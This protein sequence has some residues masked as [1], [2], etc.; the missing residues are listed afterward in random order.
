LLLAN[1]VQRASFAM[2]DLL[3]LAGGIAVLGL[4]VLYAMALRRI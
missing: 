1:R 4:Y 3:Y 2:I